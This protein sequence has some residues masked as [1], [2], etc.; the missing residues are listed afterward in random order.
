MRKYLLPLAAAAAVLGS[1]PAFALQSSDGFSTTI[2]I[3]TSCVV[4]APDLNFGNVGVISGTETVT[5]NID[6]NCSAGTAYWLSFNSD[7]L[8]INQSIVLNAAAMDNGAGSTVTYN[9]VIGGGA[10]G[11]GPA[12]YP[13]IVSLPPQVTPAPG[14]YTD[15][16]TVYVNY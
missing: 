3:Q 4:T 16:Q 2:T 7:P 5:D 14:I 6:V 15:S 12:L 8:L 1:A 11:V 10:A 13:I 9:A